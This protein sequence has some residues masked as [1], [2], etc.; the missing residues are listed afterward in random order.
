M[1]HSVPVVPPLSHREAEARALR[2]VRDFQAELLDT[3]TPFPA[4]EFF[5]FYLPQHYGLKTGVAHLPSGIEGVTTPSGEILLGARVYDSLF[6][7]DSRA[8][9]TA[10]HEAIH[11]ILHLPVTRE[12]ACQLEEGLEPRLF[13]RRELPAYLDPEWQANR[14]TGAVLMPAATMRILVKKAGKNPSA[15]ASVFQVSYSAAEV[16]LGQLGK[17]GWL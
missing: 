2:I 7:G 16:R 4:E 10:I 1:T 12:M 3:P 5:E 8:R 15:V 9:F 17:L 6:A 14:V 11:G 13:R